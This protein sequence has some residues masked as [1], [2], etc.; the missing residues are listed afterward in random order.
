MTP[1]YL[2]GAFKYPL[3]QTTRL[4][5]PRHE[6]HPSPLLLFRSYVSVAS[7]ADNKK[8]ASL[9]NHRDQFKRY[10]HPYALANCR[11]LYRFEILIKIR[12]GATESDRVR[13]FFVRDALNAVND[14]RS[15]L[16]R[17]LVVPKC[18]RIARN[19]PFIKSLSF[20]RFCR[21]Y[22]SCPPAALEF[23]GHTFVISAIL[24]DAC[25][26]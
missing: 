17:A 5:A 1:V 26:E 18:L 7:A 13:A 16:I 2:R 22:M 21:D 11:G 23:R 15:I 9:E 10:L 24:S 14:W 19:S 20:E 12:R 3:Y 25:P 4:L 6:L 8:R